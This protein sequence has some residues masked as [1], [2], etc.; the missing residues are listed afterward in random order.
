MEDRL[1]CE[2]YDFHEIQ[3]WEKEL[4]FIKDGII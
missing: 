1:N 4:V 3:T 2:W